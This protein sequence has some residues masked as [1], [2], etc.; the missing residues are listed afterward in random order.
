MACPA[1]ASGSST[2][3]ARSRA[4]LRIIASA[5]GLTL[6]EPEDGDF[7]A[8]FGAAKLA[9]AAVTGDTSARIFAQPAVRAEIAP[10]P[11]LAAAYAQKYHAYRTAWPHLRDLPA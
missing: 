3:S 11:A 9:A 1:A 5:T 10:D 6:L 7:G 2:R 4:W 8:A